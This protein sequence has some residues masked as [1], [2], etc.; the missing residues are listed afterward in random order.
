MEGLARCETATNKS[1]GVGECGECLSVCWSVGRD[2]ERHIQCSKKDNCSPGQPADKAPLFSIAD[3]M[4]DISG[5]EASQL[6]PRAV[7]LRSGDGGLLE[8]QLRPNVF[9]R[10]NRC[11]CIE[12]PSTFGPEIGDL[13]DPPPVGL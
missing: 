1:S 2:T 5:I 11:R 12:S 10:C 8:P 9:Q 3:L 13:L 6:D 7:A 4:G